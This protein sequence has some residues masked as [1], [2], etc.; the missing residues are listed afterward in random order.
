MLGFK[1]V[2]LST[3]VLFMGMLGFVTF[4]AYARKSGNTGLDMGKIHLMRIPAQ[5]DQ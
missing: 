3:L 5:A 4:K 2:V 1:L